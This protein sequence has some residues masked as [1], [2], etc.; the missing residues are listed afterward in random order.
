MTTGRILFLSALLCLPACGGDPGRSGDGPRP[1][2]GEA[3]RSSTTGPAPQEVDRPALAAVT[4]D[5]LKTEIARHKDTSKWYFGPRPDGEPVGTWLSQDADR[6][7]LMFGKDGSF[8]CGFVWRNDAGSL[9]T[10]RYAISETGLIVAVAK[11]EGARLG[12]FYRL[13]NGTILGSRGPAPR[14]EWKR[15]GSGKE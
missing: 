15:K 13:D 3:N 10:G 12:L 2:A 4:L 1:T 9:A 7:P 6:E 5:D 8:Q 11:H 14:V